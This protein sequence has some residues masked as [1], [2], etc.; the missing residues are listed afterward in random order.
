MDRG[1][2]L[3]TS[4]IDN[5]DE[6][7]RLKKDVRDLTVKC[8]TAKGAIDKVKVELDKKAE[9]RKTNVH[10]HMAAVEQDEIFK[11]D[12]GQGPSHDIIDEEEL[13]HLQNMKQLKKS[14]RG[15]FNELKGA[16]SQASQ[17]QMSIDTA[18]QSLVAEFE[19]WYESTF[20]ME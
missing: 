9:E 7:K 10:A 20:E 11:D 12:E 16:K 2:S 15:F 17:V 5:R 14:Y 13:A 6:L 18:K 8:N 3:E 4:I 1:Q 19:H